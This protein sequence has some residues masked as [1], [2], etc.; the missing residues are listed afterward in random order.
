MA[1]QITN[2]YWAT[3]MP[4]FTPQLKR[5]KEWGSLPF[6]SNGFLLYIKHKDNVNFSPSILDAMQ[7]A[8][9]IVSS[10]ITLQSSTWDGP[11]IFRDYIL[12]NSTLQFTSVIPPSGPIVLSQDEREK[13]H[14]EFLINCGLYIEDTKSKKLTSQG[15]SITLIPNPDFDLATAMIESV[16]TWRGAGLDQDELDAFIK[17][18]GVQFYELLGSDN[19]GFSTTLIFPNQDLVDKDVDSLVDT[20]EKAI[21]DEAEKKEKA[22]EKARKLSYEEWLKKMKEK[23]GG[24]GSPNDPWGPSAPDP[25]KK[26]WD[27]DPY[28]SPKPRPNPYTYP[29]DDDWNPKPYD[30]EKYKEWMQK[31]K[32]WDE[33]YDKSNA[34]SSAS[35][36]HNK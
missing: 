23:E 27:P 18:T 11:T 19:Y 15:K 29:P 10:G 25:Y 3:L 2:W 14:N 13:I 24:P 16:I 12:D 21:L 36:I 20:L 33:A 5:I 31:K 6:A 28:P 35:Q 4:V 32:D 17:I 34:A 26:P 1:K 8:A 30:Y 9:P 7:A 22:K